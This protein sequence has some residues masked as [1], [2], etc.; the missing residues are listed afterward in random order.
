MGEA[1]RVNTALE[2]REDAGEGHVREKKHNMQAGVDSSHNQAALAAQYVNCCSGKP[3]ARYRGD[4]E[5][6]QKRLFDF[7]SQRGNFSHTDDGVWITKISCPE[8]LPVPGCKR[9]FRM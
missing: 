4:T 1:L 9:K 5:E 6:H 7:N 3:T 8:L 2:R